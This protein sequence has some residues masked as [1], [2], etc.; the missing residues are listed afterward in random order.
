MKFNAGFVFRTLALLILLPLLHSCSKACEQWSYYELKSDCSDYSSKKLVHTTEHCFRGTQL[1]FIR[2]S[3]G[4]WCRLK[5]FNLPFPQ[6]HCD[7]SQTKLTIKSRQST[8]I[9]YTKRLRGGQC[10]LLPI[11]AQDLIVS[12]LSQGVPL[13]ITVGR[14]SAEITSKGF[15]KSYKRFVTN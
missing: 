14:Y 12:E 13:T 5:V 15:C 7:F 9:F 3:S 1:E 2:T 11:N 6:E 10:L 8:K 4:Q